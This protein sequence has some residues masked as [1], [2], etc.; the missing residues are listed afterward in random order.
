VRAWV[1]LSV[2]LRFGLGLSRHHLSSLYSWLGGLWGL[3]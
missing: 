3:T 1:A 2:V